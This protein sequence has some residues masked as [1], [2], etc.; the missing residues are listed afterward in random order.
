MKARRWGALDERA[1]EA[2]P[3]PVERPQHKLDGAR[4]WFMFTIVASA[5]FGMNAT[6]TVLSVMLPKLAMDFRCV[7]R[8][9]D[10][11]PRYPNLYKVL[12][13]PGEVVQY[14]SLR[15]R[16]RGNCVHR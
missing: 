4:A 5:N 14:V 9:D 1:E 7:T 2:P 6:F 13:S 10:C 12:P 3:Q 11:L 16:V 8:S 15:F